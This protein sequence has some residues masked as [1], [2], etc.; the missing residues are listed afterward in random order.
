MKNI[1]IFFVLL[2]ASCGNKNGKGIEESNDKEINPWAN[3]RL[4]EWTGNSLVSIFYGDTLTCVG[5][6]R[7]SCFHY[8]LGE[9]F[10]GETVLLKENESY[11]E[12]IE[13]LKKAKNEYHDNC[14]ECGDSDSWYGTE[15]NLEIITLYS[16]IKMEEIDSSITYL[17]SKSKT[18]RNSSRYS[19]LYLALLMKKIGRTEIEKKL[20]SITDLEKQDSILIG[21]H[22][23][24][25]QPIGEYNFNLYQN[26]KNWRH[27]FTTT[28]D[29]IEKEG[30]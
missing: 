20:G 5:P 26:K 25:W 1:L 3:N 17:N 30:I 10:Y 8:D 27:Y 6:L 22:W 2:L 23:L 9:K 18:W 13:R 19:D 28:L 16:L 21:S 7:Y 15:Q 12:F 14:T 29:R 4:L 11:P 24:H